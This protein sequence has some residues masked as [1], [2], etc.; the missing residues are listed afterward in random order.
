M[1]FGVWI[2]NLKS[3]FFRLVLENSDNPEK[4]KVSEKNELH[5]WILQVQKPFIN[6]SL[7]REIKANPKIHSS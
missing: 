2:P 3:I 7:I 5:N 6:A 1:F 4:S